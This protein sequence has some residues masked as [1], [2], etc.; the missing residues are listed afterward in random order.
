LHIDGQID[1][2][3][4]PVADAFME[5]FSTGR[6]VGAAVAVL[7]DGLPVVNVWHGHVDRKRQR[8]WREDTLVCQF[9]VTKAMTTLCVLQA[10]D[11]G[12]VALDESVAAHWPG[13]AKHHKASITVRHLLTHQAGLIGFHSS[14]PPDALYDWHAIVAALEDEFPWW[15]PGAQHGYHARTFGFLL[16]E[17]LRLTAG[18]SIGQ[19]FRDEIAGPCGLD[20]H[21]GV[22]DEDLVRCAD[23]LPAR[24]RPGD[25]LPAAAAALM[26]DVGDPGTLAN[27]AFQ[28]PSMGPGH[29]NTQAYRQAEIPAANGH[30]TALSTA[31][32]MAQ[33]VRLISPEL[34]TEATRTQSY[35]PDA[36]LRSITRFG[37]GFMLYDDEC[38]IGLRPGTFGHAGAGGS[39][40]FH[41]PEARLSFCFAM[42]QLEPGVIVGGTSAA[43]VARAVYDC[44]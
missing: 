30:G 32:A 10:I 8:L 18:R 4:A 16:G 39:V 11:R 31:K 37:L 25:R 44:L 41:D 3:F 38:P 36:V 34:L 20:F 40:A 6:D 42:N 7:L 12:L 5:G 17:L 19:W 22:S 29:M 33:T 35:G 1:P 15:P 2:R 13:F 23:I 43:A 21:I 9:S 26:R 27:A 24:M 28:N 14:M